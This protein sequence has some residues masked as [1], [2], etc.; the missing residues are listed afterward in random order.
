MSPFRR[1]RYAPGMRRI[2]SATLLAA[3]WLAV[4]GCS[5]S[6]GSVT[7]PASSG[8]ARVGV[9]Q[10]LV[11]DIGRVNASVG[12]GWELARPPDPT[13]LADLGS[14][15]AGDSPAAPGSGG[16]MTWEFR[17]VAP[18]T[19]TVVLQY[20]YR[21]EVPDDASGIPVTIQVTVG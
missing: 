14:R 12:D 17:G 1:P 2:W 9:G 18:G 16:T 8:T 13:I 15:Y 19:T 21:G 11:V 6:A 4:A 20:R 10:T 7:V 3:V 5:L